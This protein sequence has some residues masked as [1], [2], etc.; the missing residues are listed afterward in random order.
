[1]SEED[2]EKLICTPM[3]VKEYCVVGLLYGI[4]MRISELCNLRI[5]DIDSK[6]KRIKII[7]GKGSKDRYTLIPD[8]LV[9]R[10]REFYILESRPKV[11]LF[12]SKQTGRAMH[13]RSMQLVVNS[14]MEKLDSRQVSIQLIHCVI[15]LQHIYLIVAQ[16][17][18]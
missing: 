14:A 4:G 16:I 15:V 13:P 3:T 8:H 9:A 2:I 10:L 1:M 7:Q 17:C 5:A 12:T 11:Y 6:S 18:M